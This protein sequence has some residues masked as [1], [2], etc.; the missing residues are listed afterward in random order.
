MRD[1]AREEMEH[2][3]YIDE[4]HNVPVAR[5]RD[6]S[7]YILYFFLKKEK[8][9]IIVSLLSPLPPALSFTHPLHIYQITLFG[10]NIR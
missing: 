1:G 6:G 7:V 3:V 5:L 9:T 10:P 8:I 2:A 4:T